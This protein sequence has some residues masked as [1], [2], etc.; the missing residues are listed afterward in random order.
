[1]ETSAI[2]KV[3]A[4]L[5]ERYP[6]VGIRSIE[7][8]EAT[9][10]STFLLDQT[11][12]AVQA[13]A[14]LKPDE[15]I[16]PH[17]NRE[18]AATIT[19]DA[20]NRSV[21]DLAQKDPF[22]ADPKELFPRARR[23]YFSEP[24]VGGS[25]DFL[26]S[27]S[28]K[29]FEHDVDDP[30]VKNFYDAWAF[31][32]NFP[33]LIEWMF[34]E[35]FRSGNVFTYKAIAK[36]EPRVSNV[37]AGPGEK[38][39]KVNQKKA[40]SRIKAIQEEY[41]KEVAKILEIAKEEGIDSEKLKEMEQAA[42][43]NIWSKGHLPISYTVLNPELV[44]V[45]GNLLFNASSIKITLPTEL[46]EAI[47]KDSADLSE[48]EKQLLKMLPP[49]I[50]RSAEEGGEVLLD[51]RLVGRI[52]Y[53]K[54]P[55]EKYARPKTTRVFD[56]IEYK[57]ALKQADLS[58][59]D[60]ISNYILKITIGSDE[61]P[62]TQQAELEAVAQLFNTP[63]KSF[64][65]V[66]NH[67]LQIEKIVSPEIENI[68]GRAKYEQVNNDLTFGLGVSR[69]FIDGADV[70]IAA[71]EAALITKGMMEEISYARRQVTRWIYKEYRLIAEAMGFETFPKIRWDEGVL[72][73]TILY[74]STL[75]QLVDRR[76]LS[77]RTALEP[78]GFDYPNELENMETELPLVTKGTIGIV[79]SPFQQ[80]AGG[81]TQPKQSAPKG[82]PSGGRPKGQ[83]AKKKTPVTNPDKKVKQT[84]KKPKQ[85]EAS[86]A[87]DDIIRDM[88]AEE[89]AT[90]MY[91]VTR[92]RNEE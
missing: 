25:T 8:D 78:L 36:Y 5:K 3:T 60:G 65:V 47:S 31:D 90:F 29:G 40:A 11:P 73:D 39:K 20:I 24:L 27:I 87:F 18:R 2:E 58:T 37:S 81:G 19:R 28:A 89:F 53:R 84:T 77:Y 9:G 23:Y 85:S 66:W 38:P 75:A 55:Y 57:K 86:V 68:L 7:V 50:K 48:D 54:Q 70:D 49:D 76:M 42:K 10:K 17:I 26:A 6:D 16:T 4:E 92:M 41:K 1:M 45:E 14:Y 52:S 13:L 62:V 21:L 51:S 72:K 82:T 43:K 71:S 30:D 22:D 34:L 67:T 12:K 15:A 59:L 33:E 61:Y 80:A 91:E 35:F 63:S 46:K 79:G 74:M 88:S 64:D 56:S 32:V 69:G 83:P 44:T